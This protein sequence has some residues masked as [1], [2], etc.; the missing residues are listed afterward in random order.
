MKKPNAYDLRLNRLNEASRG[1]IPDRVPVTALVETYALA[2]SGVPLKETQKNIFKHIR[3]YGEIYKDVYFDAAFTPCVSHALNLGWTLGSDV[4][5]VSDDGIT[6]QHKE[7]CPMDASDYAAM[8]KDPVAFIL[9]EFLPRKFPKFN[10]T[11]DEQLKAFKSTLAPFVQ[12][13]L[14]LM[15]SSLYFRHILKVPVLSGGSAE[16]PCDML[17]DYTRGFKGTITDIRRHPV[18]VEKTVNALLDYCFDLVK[19]TQLLM[20]STSGNPAWLIDN[21][22][23]SVIGSRDPKLLYFPWIFNPC[24]IPPFLGPEQFD[25]FYWPTY[26]AM[27]EKIHYCG[28]HMLTML[29]GSWGPH[30]DRIN[31]LPPHSVTFIAEKDDIFELKKK[32]GKDFC[33]MGGMPVEMLRDSSTKECIDYAK[34]VIDECAVDG[35]FIFCTDKVLMSPSDANIKNLRAVNEFVHVYGQY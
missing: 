6:L 20:G 16:M 24:H 11:N 17:F 31:E 14:T 23:N 26:K 12:F 9:D 8:A 32:I 34:K 3:A 28:G 22:I 19:M 29:E 10:G 21:A 4:F 27:A 15:M 5:F 7:Y 25:K 18:E 33:I 35:G 13:A 2:Y 30:L 1:H